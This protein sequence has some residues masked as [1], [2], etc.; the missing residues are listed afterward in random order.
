MCVLRPPFPI[1]G[2][3]ECPQLPFELC[4]R[5]WDERHIPNH[6]TDDVSMYGLGL[7]RREHWPLWMILFALIMALAAATSGVPVQQSVN[8]RLLYAGQD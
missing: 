6:E 8:T 4:P 7:A 3:A 1:S 5:L 2:G